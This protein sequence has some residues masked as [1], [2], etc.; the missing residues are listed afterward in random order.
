MSSY[1]QERF[2]ELAQQEY[3]QAPPSHKQGYEYRIRLIPLNTRCH[4]KDQIENGDANQGRTL[5]AKPCHQSDMGPR[6]CYIPS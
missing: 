2:E 5:D 3:Q 4:Q 1:V 6:M